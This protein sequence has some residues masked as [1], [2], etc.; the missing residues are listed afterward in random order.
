M[1]VL[2]ICTILCAVAM[3]GTEFTVAFI[4][5]PALDG[6]DESTWLRTMPALAKAM[7]RAMPVWY[8]TTSLLAAA[9]AYLRF[10]TSAGWWIVTAAALWASSIVFSITMLVPINNRIASASAT[11]ASLM[12]DHD[13]WDGLHRWR[14]AL[15]LAATACLL[16][17]IL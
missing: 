2:D 10:G 4:L 7:G 5:N 3:T 15:L 6:L 1:Q 9:E 16:I 17:G 12:L 11:S 14:V 13:R 8:A